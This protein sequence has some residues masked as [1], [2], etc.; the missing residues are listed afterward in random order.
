MRELLIKIS[1]Y[2]FLAAILATVIVRIMFG[3]EMIVWPTILLTYPALILLGASVGLADF[4]ALFR[5]VKA[6]KPSGDDSLSVLFVLGR[7]LAFAGVLVLFLS[8]EIRLV[9]EVLQSS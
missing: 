2:G 7:G 1:V 5:Y 4:A 8:F 9:A 3:Y 6:G